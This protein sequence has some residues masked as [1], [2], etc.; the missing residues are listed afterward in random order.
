MKSIRSLR[1]VSVALMLLVAFLFQGT[2]ALAG[3]TGSLSG[4]VT[5]AKGAPVAG[6]SVT[7]TSP[8]Q[9]ASTTTDAG[10]HFNFISL[11]P[12]TYSVAVEKK[13][14]NTTTQAGVTVFADQNYT[15]AV[16][17]NDLKTIVKITSSA[18]GNLVKAGT[19][20]NVYS[21]NAA[22]QAAVAGIGG[23]GNLTNAYSAIY[24][25]PGVS[26]YIGNQGFGQVF[27]IRGASYDQSGY[28][29]DGVP[30]NR[31]FDNYNANSLSSLGQQ[32]L[33]V[34]T[35]SSPGGSSSATQAGFINQVIKTGTYP[36]FGNLQVGFGAPAFFHQLQ[37]EAGGA[38]PN[39]MFSYYIGMS[40]G[41]NAYN[42]I[43]N[44]NGASIP[45]DGTGSNGLLSGYVN[46]LVLFFSPA[47]GNGPW[48][49]CNAT[50]GAP[51][52]GA[53][54]ETYSGAALPACNFYT[55][56]VAGVNYI[57][58]DRETV[59]NFH[60]AIPHKKDG[61]RDDFQLL[62]NNFAY[63]SLYEN[64]LNQAFGGTAG[65]NA[66]YSSLTPL[67]GPNPLGTLNYQDGHIF[68]VGTTFGQ[69]VTPT[70]ASIP[71]FAPSTGTDP[72]NRA[73]DPNAQDGIWN[74]GSIIKLQYQKNIGSNAYL[75]L[76]GYSFYS[77]WLQT[78]PSGT[79]MGYQAGYF[80]G[81]GAITDY[82]LN[83]HT[84]GVQLQYANQIND[85]NLVRATFNYTTATVLRMNNSYGST[86][87]SVGNGFAVTNLTDGTN[88]YTAATGALNTCYS[89]STA[90][91]YGAPLGAAPPAG[92]P[93]A[94]AGAQYLVTVPGL[95]GGTYNKIGPKFG[96]FELDDE[97]R[98]T[99]RL[100][101]NFIG[102]FESYRY[103]LT[104]LNTAE[105]NFWFAQ[106]QKSYCVSTTT[107]QPITTQPGPGAPPGSAA[108]ITVFG[109]C[110]GGSAHPDGLTAGVPIFTNQSAYVSA[111]TKSLFSPRVSGTYTVNRDT[112]IR[113]AA[114]KFTQATPT[115]FEQYYEGSGKATTSF[116]FSHF[117][118]LGFNTPVH[119]NPIQISANYDIGLEK[120]LKGT[121]ISLKLTPFYRSATNQSVLVPLGGNFVSAVNVGIQK[122]SGVEFAI[123]KGDPSRNG[124]SGQLSWTYVH[125]RIRYTAAAPGAANAID[126][127][128]SYIRQYNSLT[129]A[130]AGNT[131][132]VSTAPNDNNPNHFC[133]TS[134]ASGACFNPAATNPSN[135]ALGNAPVA[136]G[137]ATLI[138][139]PYYNA[140]AQ[141]L[142]DD[143]AYYNTYANN[144]PGNPG[145]GPGNTAFGPNQFSA[146]LSY[147][148]GKLQ[149]I[150]NAV[151]FQGN[152]YGD[153]VDVA[154]G[155]DP[156]TCGANQA[157]VPGVA[158]AYQGFANYQTCGYAPAALGTN[159]YLAIPDPL[160]NR[161]DSVGQ[162]RN[163]WQ[164]NLGLA[165]KYDVNP[166]VSA[167]LTMANL[168]NRCFG[169][170]KPSWATQYP[171]NNI[172]C[173]YTPNE[174]NFIGTQPG[175]GFFYG[176]SGKDAANGT[177]AYPSQFN[178]PYAPYS[179]SLPFQAY[180]QV[181]VKL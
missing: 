92:S 11:A 85:K 122:T 140:P 66:A 163:P 73:L 46:P 76:L 87:A 3:T 141:P 150:P 19:T 156:R 6:A 5:D 4:N 162:Y 25:T 99:E 27:Y 83:T 7:V 178:S 155:L 115:A 143:N 75:R 48:S 62:F 13:G 102:R 126:V 142:L 172:V 1:R 131:G 127:M 37:I 38:T 112:V 164:F 88:C 56:W 128:N 173:G 154:Y 42:F 67:F 74:N 96:T 68:P 47:Y 139:N 81:F 161:F 121:D 49:S 29:Y 107:G 31:A 15:I 60:F 165:I 133:A 149:I 72:T 32:E 10:G 33:Q 34:Y 147:K 71:Y 174:F 152:K 94:L 55:P 124:L 103:D 151:L 40:G 95:S 22:T 12:D 104:G 116:L 17:L 105:Q 169:G 120:H 78:A 180:L 166:K 125:A 117:Y 138:T 53:A 26:S 114:G 64:S 24:S 175:A 159:G 129:S 86:N 18:A 61:G 170:D 63:H 39:R 9:Q 58:Q 65:I 35:G 43:D 14:Y 108:P 21:V 171:A 113:F 100:D 89:S 54:T 179:G 80:P 41:N 106:A 79:A 23:G 77:D 69:V 30:V 110:P 2:W 119:D 136:C 84:R 160:T 111:I 145:D 146:F 57:N 70:L 168:V 20:A 130:C 91:T 101:L 59:A 167:T 153:P 158:A 123:Q 135:P 28:E 118:G 82:E 132:A 144:P 8:S 44:K 97:Y 90:G 176:A 98:P 134:A 51:Q 50:T 45:L 16:V 137:G 157:G 52:T 109:A 181:N 36:G 148:K 177:A 93:A